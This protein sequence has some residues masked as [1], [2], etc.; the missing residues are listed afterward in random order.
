MCVV[1]QTPFFNHHNQHRSRS[2]IVFERNNRIIERIVEDLDLS[3]EFDREEQNGS[4]IGNVV[5]G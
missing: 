3:L 4:R 5:V 1:S 2:K